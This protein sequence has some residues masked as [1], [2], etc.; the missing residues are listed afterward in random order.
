MSLPVDLH[1]D[2]LREMEDASAW[3]E[4]QRSGLGFEFVADVERVLARVAEA[5]GS[6]PAWRRDDSAKKAV[7]ARFPYVLLFDVESQRVLVLAV[8]HGR[9]RPGYWLARRTDP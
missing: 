4:G 6:F 9:R 2:A 8:A 3:Y 7:C 5:P 1:A